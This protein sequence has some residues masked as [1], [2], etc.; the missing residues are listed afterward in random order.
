MDSDEVDSA[1][2]AVVDE[3]L[4]PSFARWSRGDSWRTELVALVLQGLEIL[5][6]EGSS[7]SRI[8]VSLSGVVGF[9]ETQCVL[10]ITG[11]DEVLEIT[12]LLCTPEHGGELQSKGV[13]ASRLPRT[14][15]VDGGNFAGLEVLERGIVTIGPSE[16]DLCATVGRWGFVNR[17]V[18]GAWFRGGGCGFVGGGSDLC[19]AHSRGA[20][21]GLAAPCVG[22]F[23]LCEKLVMP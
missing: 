21:S 19:R 4:Q 22:A 5:L 23:L 2:R 13:R 9:I 16:S 11:F 14:P 17:G 7:I 18:G 1:T 8:E 20:G 12:N 3:V 6:P 15:G 10:G